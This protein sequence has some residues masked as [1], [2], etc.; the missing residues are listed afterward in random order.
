MASSAVSTTATNSE[1]LS[2]VE[3]WKNHLEPNYLTLPDMFISFLAQPLVLNPQYEKK[4][5]ESEAWMSERLEYTD[6]ERT[7]RAHADFA[8]CMS[9]FAPDAGPDELRTLCDW[10]QFV[11][12]FDDQF[13]NGPMKNDPDK[14]LKEIKSII[15]TM[16]STGPKGAS[17][18]GS[19]LVEVFRSIWHRI[20]TGTSTETQRRHREAMTEYC[21]GLIQQVSISSSREIPDLEEYLELRRRTSGVPP[22]F[23]L[24]DQHLNLPNAIFANASICTLQN[25]AREL[26]LLSASSSPPARLV[27]LTSTSQNDLLSYSKEETQGESHN[28]VIIYR[29]S[30]VPPQLAFEQI[31]KRLK[32]C[33]RNWSQA[34]AD[35]PHWGDAIDEQVTKYVAGLQHLVQANLNW[36]FRTERYFGKRHDDVRKTGAFKAPKPHVFRTESGRMDEN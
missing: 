17:P 1:H 24:I 15:A 27:S 33:H 26:I 8:Y 7:K 25:L 4:K 36:S 30:G 31:D 21:H 3:G 19:P 11:F 22:L 13:D 18:Q 14:A 6:K 9:V 16:D 10:F 12:D 5:A 20:A 28:L 2:S 35:L 23:S 29:L 32:A 34:E